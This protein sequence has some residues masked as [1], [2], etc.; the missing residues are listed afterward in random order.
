[1]RKL[2][3][4]VAVFL[5]AGVTVAR[6][7]ETLDQKLMTL[8]QGHTMA[9]IDEAVTRVKKQLADEAYKKN[10]LEDL[11]KLF[12]SQIQRLQDRG[13]P[14][15]IVNRFLVMRD[16]VV[17]RASN[18]IIGIG[19]IPFIPVI[20]LSVRGVYDL[21][22]MVDEE[23]IN[24][25][26]TDRTTISDTVEVPK[27]FFYYIYDVENGGS[28]IG[29]SPEEALKIFNE[30]D[31]SPLTVAEVSAL[32]VHTDVLSKHYLIAAGSQADC[33]TE[34]MRASSPTNDPLCLKI[35]NNQWPRLTK[36]NGDLG[37][38][39][40]GSRYGRSKTTVASDTATAIFQ[41]GR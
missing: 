19:N 23:K 34:V 7:D 21:M 39:S 37:L 10:R 2:T 38:P 32:A 11:G 13:V 28:T 16:E 12:D 20:T 17:H 41:R 3:T 22:A 35:I 40:C 14:E 25:L 8:F 15:Q 31:R 33:I 26:I 29:K 4:V 30:Q 1:M 18:M 27:S 9:E 6:A 5:V 36:N 24:V